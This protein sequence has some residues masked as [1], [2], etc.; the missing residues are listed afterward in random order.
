MFGGAKVAEF[1][2]SSGWVEEEVLGLD[3]PVTDSKGVDVRQGA[4]QL[5]HVQL[6]VR[7]R[8]RLLVLG[9]VTG[10]FVDGF[11]DVLQYEVQIYFVFLQWIF[12]SFIVNN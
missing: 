9:I 7:D 4:E 5:V 6:Y 3:V 11:R 10:Y 1:E 2:N 8:D 12:V